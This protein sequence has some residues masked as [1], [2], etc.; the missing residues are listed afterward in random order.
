MYSLMAMAVLNSID[1]LGSYSHLTQNEDNPPII[2]VVLDRYQ[3]Q[4]KDNSKSVQAVEHSFYGS[5]AL[6][7]VRE[8]SMHGFGYSGVLEVLKPVL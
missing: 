6:F 2:C 7:P 4:S 5:I 3:M 1:S 8:L